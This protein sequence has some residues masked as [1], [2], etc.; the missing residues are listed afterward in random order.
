MV[1]QVGIHSEKGR[2]CTLVN[3]WPGKSIDVFRDG[4]KVETL[5]GDRVVL[6][7]EAGATFSLVS[8]GS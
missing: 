5:L 8:S 4:K 7:T 2:P 1:R 6:Q 3:P